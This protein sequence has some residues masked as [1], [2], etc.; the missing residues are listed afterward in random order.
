MTD[1]LTKSFLIF[2]KK[3]QPY[4]RFDKSR[5]NDGTKIPNGENFVTAPIGEQ[6]KQQSIIFIFWNI[7]QIVTGFLDI[8]GGP[9]D[10]IVNL[11]WGVSLSVIILGN[12]ELTKDR[13]PSYFKT[14]GGVLASIILVAT[15]IEIA[16][17]P[18]NDE[19]QIDTT[20]F[21]LFFFFN[22]IFNYFVTEGIYKNIFRYLILG[23]AIAGVFFTGADIFFDFQ[24]PETLQP[25]FLIIFIGFTVGLGYGTYDAW[26]NYEETN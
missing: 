10:E 24:P 8:S 21:Y 9:I 3:K 18:I 1:L 23:A 11:T 6:A 22:L 19:P 2:M 7:Y 26:K 5:L 17:P 14:S 15:F 16:N 13:V 20:G 25:L 12:W 4:P